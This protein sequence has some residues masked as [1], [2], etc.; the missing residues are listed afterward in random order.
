MKRPLCSGL[1]GWGG[2]DLNP[3]PQGYEFSLALSLLFRSIIYRTLVSPFLP[4]LARFCG[5]IVVR[6]VP[7][8]IQKIVRHCR[9][10]LPWNTLKLR[11]WML[12]LSVSRPCGKE[13]T[14]A[15]TFHLKVRHIKREN[16]KMKRST[17]GRLVARLLF[18]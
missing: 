17:E 3:R 9:C 13:I 11:K 7:K 8:K 12:S 10:I 15:R 5:V 16:M 4:L 18:C 6:N 1:I 14:K 2:R